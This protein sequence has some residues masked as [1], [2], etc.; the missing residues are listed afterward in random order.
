MSAEGV[1]DRYV[2]YMQGVGKRFLQERARMPVFK[3]LPGIRVRAVFPAAC[4][5]HLRDH[6][7][8]T[9]SD[10]DQ[11]E[12]LERKHPEVVP[13]KQKPIR[14]EMGG[15]RTEQPAGSGRLTR[16]GRASFTKVY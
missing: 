14:V 8:V 15:E 1:R 11:I 16:F 13:E 2:A 3:D 6:H 12:W 10:K 9:L 7:G 5:Y 4:Y